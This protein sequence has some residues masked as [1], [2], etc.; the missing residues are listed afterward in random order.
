MIPDMSDSDAARRSESERLRVPGAAFL[1]SQVGAHSSRLWRERMA[2]L[3]LDPRDV[4]LLRH[5]AAAEGQSQQA[6]AEALQIPA[7]RMVALVDG[8]E[9]SGLLERRPVHGDRR[10]RAL[11]LTRDGRRVLGR[12][13]RVSAEHEAELS[14]GLDRAEREQLI[15]LLSR[16]AAEQ[17][18]PTGVHPG[19]A[20]ETREGDDS[21]PRS[22]Q[23]EEPPG[24]PP[25]DGAQGKQR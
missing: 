17:G 10:V 25:R 13:M 3:N 14:R 5:V 15:A 19:V 11:H 7:S 21:E 22:A 24:A 12:V 1:L 20:G 4:V 23:A 9:Q 8:L 16:L 2:R 18:L 6:L